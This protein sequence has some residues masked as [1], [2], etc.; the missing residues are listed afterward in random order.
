[1]GVLMLLVF[2]KLQDYFIKSS[3]AWHWAAIFA[4][5]QTLITGVNGAALF[6]VWSTAAILFVYA[7]AYF[8]L[9]RYVKDNLLLWIIILYSGA[10][11]FYFL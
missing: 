6:G 2:V 10:L 11:V 1:M 3:R 7:W 5:L 4:V 9:L 8:A